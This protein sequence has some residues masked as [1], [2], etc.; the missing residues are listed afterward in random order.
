MI[1]F[2]LVVEI[3][4]FYLLGKLFDYKR[5]VVVIYT[6]DTKQCFYTFDNP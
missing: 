3:Y 6:F 2:D 1:K 5:L 4:K